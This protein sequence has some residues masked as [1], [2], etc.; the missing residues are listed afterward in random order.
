MFKNIKSTLPYL[1]LGILGYLP[2]FYFYNNNKIEMGG[3]IFFESFPLL[4]SI[5]LFII[6][7]FCLFFILRL[8]EKL[9]IKKI[10]TK[11]YQILSKLISLFILSILSFYLSLAILVI[12]LAIFSIIYLLLFFNMR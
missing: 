11:T 9:I 3:L 5:P 6:Y 2:I 7:I 10:K 8:T 4:L 12:F 1:A